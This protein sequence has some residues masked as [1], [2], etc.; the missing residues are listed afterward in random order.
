MSL[1]TAEAMG[2]SQ[3]LSSG[4]GE[5]FRIPFASGGAC[6]QNGTGPG[7]DSFPCRQPDTLPLPCTQNLQSLQGQSFLALQGPWVK[8]ESQVASAAGPTVVLGTAALATSC[9][10]G[11]G[12]G[13][14]ATAT[15][16]VDLSGGVLSLAVLPAVP[17]SCQAT[18][19]TY[20]APVKEIAE[21]SGL[22]S[23]MKA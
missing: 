13:G 10:R 14:R 16:L 1:L 5:C 15:S 6:A 19:S 20:I 4:S 12:N 8:L 17:V 9:W 23:Q 11:P 18:A 3:L 7:L 2:E 22:T 21:L